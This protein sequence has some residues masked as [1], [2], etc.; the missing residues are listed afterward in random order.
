[1]EVSFLIDETSRLQD[2]MFK[3]FLSQKHTVKRLFYQNMIILTEAIRPLQ[4]WSIFPFIRC[5]S[6]EAGV[7]GIECP[8]TIS[9]AKSL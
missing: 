1:M 7:K 6:K 5:V 2:V 8:V 3:V 4:Y 9:K